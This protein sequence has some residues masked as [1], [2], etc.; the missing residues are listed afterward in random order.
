LEKAWN[1]SSKGFLV[2]GGAMADVKDGAI[3]LFRAE[4]A[5]PV[6]E[7]AKSDPYVLNGLVT[8]WRVKEWNTVA[9]EIAVNPVRT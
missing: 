4:T 6:E 3:L 2:L 5:A 8:N 9:G 7:F 1:A